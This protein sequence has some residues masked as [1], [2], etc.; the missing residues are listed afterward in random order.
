MAGR[1]G[2]LSLPV[3]GVALSIEPLTLE[4][5]EGMGTKTQIEGIDLW[6]GGEGET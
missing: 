2:P 6:R 3:P 1:T 4:K 5:A